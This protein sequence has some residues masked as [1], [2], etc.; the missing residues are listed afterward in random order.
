MGSWVVSLFE[1]RIPAIG[2]GV[3]RL[4][5]SRPINQAVNATKAIAKMIASG[6]GS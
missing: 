6:F 2:T 3:Q 5:R 4:V 1:K